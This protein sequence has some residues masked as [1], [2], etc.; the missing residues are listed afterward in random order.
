M[1]VECTH[2]QYE[3]ACALLPAGRLRP[4][5]LRPARR[6]F[7]VSII[8]HTIH[9]KDESTHSGDALISDMGCMAI[10]NSS[11]AHRSVGTR[12]E[13]TLAP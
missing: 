11:P 12:A 5:A 6:E 8:S 10:A 2:T 9:D 13:H 4:C 3:Y 7:A 1:R